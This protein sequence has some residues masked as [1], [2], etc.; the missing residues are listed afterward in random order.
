MGMNNQVKPT[1]KTSITMHSEQE[2][3]K[4]LKQDG[5]NLVSSTFFF[6]LIFLYT[7]FLFHSSPYEPLHFVSLVIMKWCR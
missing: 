6:Y 7:P 1:T 3:G 4:R 2:N 5:V